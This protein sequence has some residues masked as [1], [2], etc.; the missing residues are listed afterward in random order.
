[1]LYWCTVSV[2]CAVLMYSQ[3]LVCCID[4]QSVSG[5]P[6]WCTVHTSHREGQ[7]TLHSG[8]VYSLAWRQFS[9]IPQKHLFFP[10]LY[11]F[12]MTEWIHVCSRFEASSQS[13]GTVVIKHIIIIVSVHC[14]RWQNVV[15]LRVRNEKACCTVLSSGYKWKN[16]EFHTKNFW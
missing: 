11:M 1:V 16:W 4:V 14:A 7:A 10:G 13:D 8:I 9:N 12:Q 3:C 5:V 2:W 6:H 15:K